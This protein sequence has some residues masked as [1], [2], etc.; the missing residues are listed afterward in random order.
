MR[1]TIDGRICDLPAEPVAVPGFDARELRDANRCRE[2]RSLQLRLPATPANDRILAF[3]RDPHAAVRFDETL[4]TAELA[5]DGA[6]LAAGTV[7]LLAAADDGYTV[8]IRTGGAGWAERMARTAFGE[9]PVA[10]AARLTA[11]TIRKSWTEPVPVRFLPVH[12]DAY[13]RQNG[14]ADLLPAQRQLS[15]NDYHPFLHIATLV[16]SAAEAAGYT[17]ESGFFET[18]LFRSLYMSGA[19]PRQETGMLRRRMD[20]R[21]GRKTQATAAADGMGRVY[22]NPFL[23]VHSV[24]NLV[25]TAAAGSSAAEADLYDNGRCFGIE[26]GRIR[27]RP[28]TA[29]RIGFEYELHYTTQHRILSRE[30]LTGFDGVALGTGCDVR[31]EL[32]NRYVDRRESLAASHA[33][34]AVVFE[35]AEGARYRLLLVRNGVQ[36][37][38]TEFAARTALVTTPAGDGIGAAELRIERGGTWVSYDGDWALYDG[39]VEETGTTAVELH[40]PAPAETVTPGTPKRFDAIYFYG[41]EE[42]MELTLLEGCRLSPRFSAAPGYGETVTF[43][44]TAQHAVRQIVLFDALQH[45]FNLRFR[46]DEPHRKLYVE[47]AET[48]YDRTRIAD[49]SGKT[50]FAEPIV[51][52]PVAPETHEI[53][54]WCYREGDGAVRRRDAEADDGPFGRWSAETGGFAAR[55]GEERNENPLFSPTISA[56]GY[57]AEAPSALLPQVGDRDDAAA[58]DERFTPRIVRYCGMRTLPEGERWGWPS[59]GTSYPLA[60]FHL[61]EEEPEA[62]FTLCFEDRDGAQGL[63]RFYDRQIAQ[64]RLGE[65]IEISLRIEPREFEALFAADGT[66]GAGTADAADG[67]GGATVRS[68]FRLGL[69]AE[70]VLATLERIESYDPR[71]ASTRCVF[72]RLPEDAL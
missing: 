21:A 68:V 4:H 57:C 22:A 32:P 69:G 54:T 34:R 10:Y 62:A 65:R 8:E 52:R 31:F 37:V 60:A 36:T 71:A 25:E 51:R 6:T 72:T 27:F 50:D 23:T 18:D 39:Y 42:G 11:E 41:A 19:Y 9:I 1:L 49:W 14:G 67:T 3:A 35:H 13:P 48:F 24:G 15:A 43:A 44:Q 16:R 5:C 63:H 7:R 55:M 2:G 58:D 53:R 17:I 61:P 45:L 33:Y 56:A 46:T 12:R 70:S 64:E 20:F 40:V 66:G 28:T 59:N 26:E 47:P 29:V 38:W 30:R